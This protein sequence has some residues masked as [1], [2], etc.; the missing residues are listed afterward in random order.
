MI[1]FE[2]RCFEIL[3]L[4]RNALSRL[5]DQK[6]F[7]RHTRVHHCNMMARTAHSNYFNI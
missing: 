3:K 4:Y 6:R 1:G 5:A 7:P 2:N